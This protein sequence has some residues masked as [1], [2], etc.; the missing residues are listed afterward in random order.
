MKIVFH[1]IDGCLNADANTPIP[2][3]NER[4]SQNQL[5][6]LK[7]LGRKLDVSS[8]DHLVI[9]TGRAMDETLSVVNGIASKKLQY[10]I[11]EHGAVYRDVINNKCIYPLGHMAEKLELIVSFISWYRETGAKILNE[12][13][14]TEVPILGKA[15]NL[16][17]D[18]R[19]GLDS[20]HIYDVLKTMVKSDA[21]FDYNQL[22]FHHSKP[23]GFVDVM[24]KIDKG[25][26]IEVISSL[27]SKLENPAETIRSIAIGNGLNDMSML[28]VA[29][30]PVCPR[31]SEHE[32]RNFCRSRSGVVSE[33]EYI[34]A[35]LHWLE[36]YT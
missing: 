4:L 22:I 34:D 27:I 20:Q 28:E 21:P 17:L 8:I 3:G 6:K 12:R 14:G 1:D 16:T 25:N 33:F 13:V 15:A 11:A 36:E 30:I 29:T 32:V 23:D 7:E 19:N 24:G 35:T 26:G 18:A 5:A 9:N 10:V 31:N 2:I